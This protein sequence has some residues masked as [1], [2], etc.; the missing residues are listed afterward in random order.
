M[1]TPNSK[2]RALTALLLK[3]T[4]TQKRYRYDVTMALTKKEY[5]HH[6]VLR[7]SYD[8]STSLRSIVLFV[9]QPLSQKIQ[10]SNDY[11]RNSRTTVFFRRCLLLVA[12]R[13][14]RLLAGC[15]LS[16]SPGTATITTA[17]QSCSNCWNRHTTAIPIA[18]VL[19]STD[20]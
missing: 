20:P 4:A 7:S 12:R 16:A 17:G 11:F 3:C 14:T 13:S 6:S 8:I 15:S 19:G 10:S 9:D 1:Q 18:L 2:H 5:S